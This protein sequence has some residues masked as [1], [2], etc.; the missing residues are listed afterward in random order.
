VLDLAARV[1][2]NDQIDQNADQDPDRVSVQRLS[3]FSVA[4]S[5]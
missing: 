4:V 5:S 3:P 2:P 1:T